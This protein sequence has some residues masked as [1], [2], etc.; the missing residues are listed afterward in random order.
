MSAGTP[1]ARVTRP[2]LTGHVGG[3]AAVV[4]G[5]AAGGGVEQAASATAT[6]ISVV[7]VVGIIGGSLSRGDAS[8]LA[9]SL[10]ELSNGLIAP[11][12]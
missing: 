4:V 3:A 9:P 7:R 6:E 2:S 8:P 1:R 12:P 5:G 10:P 11:T